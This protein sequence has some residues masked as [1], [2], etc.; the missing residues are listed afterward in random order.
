MGKKDKRGNTA[1]FS[2]LD[3]WIFEHRAYRRLSLPARA[4]MW[5]LIRVFNGHNNGRL[6]LAH[7]KAAER[8]GCHRNSVGK[9]YDELEAA[10][11]VRK[12]RD[13]CLGSAG[14]GQA[15]HWALTH[16]GVDGHRATLDFKSKKP[17]Q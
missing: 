13:H 5:E 3:N 8:L 12:T 15:K 4:L 14:I 7:R 17:A 2:K 16:F 10:G 1:S 6:F 11:F 9:Y